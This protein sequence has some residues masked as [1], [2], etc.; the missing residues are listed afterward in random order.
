[1]SRLSDLPL[2]ALRIGRNVEDV[3]ASL[4]TDVSEPPRIDGAEHFYNMLRTAVDEFLQTQ[5]GSLV[6]VELAERVSALREV[7][8][9]ARP[10]MTLEDVVLTVNW[11]VFR[12]DNAT[13]PL[14]SR[15]FV[16]SIALQWYQEGLR[17]EAKET[18]GRSILTLL[19]GE[20]KTEE[21]MLTE[22]AQIIKT[23][24]T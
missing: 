16:R 12:S 22:F 8:N 20:P 6:G 14:E 19:D 1:M 5:F 17:D 23:I 7:M 2:L 21:Q 24:Q 10:L 4:I 3:P 11:L 13:A 15:R 9:L 18:L